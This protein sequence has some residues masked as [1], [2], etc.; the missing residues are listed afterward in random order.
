MTAT[1]SHDLQ[2]LIWPDDDLNS[3]PLLYL[4]AGA[5]TAELHGKSGP[6]EL[7][8]G[9]KAGFDTYFNLFSLGKWQRHCALDDL[10]LALWGTG[11]LRVV[12]EQCR[13]GQT[14][15][16]VLDQS[17]T[18]DDPGMPKR[19]NL[20]AALT[21]G[22]NATGCGGVLWFR[23]EAQGPATLADAAWQTRQP[24]LHM[25]HSISTSAEGSVKGK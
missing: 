10:H 4:R 7:A 5:G 2:R 20:S 1:Q 21:D 19:L 11:T 17:L 3:E 14:P 25:T 15:A 13:P 24:P 16:I 23:L 9:A 22:P 12:V 8:A 18:L 6:L